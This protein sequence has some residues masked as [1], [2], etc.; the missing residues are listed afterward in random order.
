MFFKKRISFLD[1]LY[2]IKKNKYPYRVKLFLGNCSANYI[3]DVDS[4]CY[5]LEFSKDRG[6]VFNEYLNESLTDKQMIAYNIEIEDNYLSSNV[7][8]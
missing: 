1:L 7:L 8:K 2:L 4:N 3:F 5:V 6:Y